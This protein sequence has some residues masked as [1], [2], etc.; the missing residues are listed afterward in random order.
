M[1]KNLQYILTLLTIV[2]V[3]AACGT[4]TK[5]EESTPKT[6]APKTEQ[7][8]GEQQVTTKDFPQL[9]TEVSDDERLVEMETSMGNVKIKLFPEYAP[10]AVENFIKHSE[11]GYYDGLIFHRVIKDFMIQG[12]DPNGNGTGGESIYGTPFE[13]EFSDHLYNLRGALS[14]ANSGTNTNGSQFF[15]VQS[16]SLDP[17]MKEQME[18]AG[19]PK[20]ILEAYDKNGGTPWLDHRHTVFG[21]VIDGMEIVDKIANTPVG[22]QDKPEKDVTIKKINVLK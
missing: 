20:E 1:R 18:K 2:L 15:I 13:D 9:S 22:A 16:T 19:Y 5:K 14:M 17:A 4:S 8:E 12:G 11:E 21:Q 3:L 7:K 10:K 6:T